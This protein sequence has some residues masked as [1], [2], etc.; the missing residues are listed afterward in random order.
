M[1]RLLLIL[2]VIFPTEINGVRRRCINSGVLFSDQIFRS[3]FVIYGE[4]IT[5]NV[6]RDTNT[7]LLFNLTFRVDCV[8]K[9]EDVANNIEITEAGKILL[10]CFSSSLND[11]F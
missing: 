1:I 7:E 3:P 6:Y 9:G 8:F 10:F 5:K 4:A 11:I 2:F